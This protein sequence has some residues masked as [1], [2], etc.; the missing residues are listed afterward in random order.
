MQHELDYYNRQLSLFW[1]HAPEYSI[2]SLRNGPPPCVEGVSPVVEQVEFHIY[3][4]EVCILVSGT[5]LWFSR[6]LTFPKIKY[7]LHTRTLENADRL[8]QVHSKNKSKLLS[9]IDGYA[10]EGVEQIKVTLGMCL[11]V[12]RHTR[13]VAFTVKVSHTDK[14]ELCVYISAMYFLLLSNYRISRCLCDKRSWQICQIG[15]SLEFLSC[16]L[17]WRGE[18]TQNLFKEEKRCTLR[19]MKTSAHFCKRPL[20]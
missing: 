10:R 19:N 8:I 2:P 14:T 1:K 15:N 12:T 7:M 4:H 5:D 18:A 16:Q 9:L 20:Q 11:D 13:N 17:H 6:D 3:E